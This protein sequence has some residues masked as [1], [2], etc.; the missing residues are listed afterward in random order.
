M[1]DRIMMV[2]TGGAYYKETAPPSEIAMIALLTK[3][4][5]AISKLCE[6]YSVRKLE[7]F[8]SANTDSWNAETSDVDFV[9]DLGDFGPGVAD[10]YLDLIDELQQLLGRPVTMITYDS[11]RN[12]YF[13][14]EVDETKV[15]FYEASHSQAIA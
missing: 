10:R 3:N 9:V 12:P 2:R 5:V 6:K 4:K 8:G 14:E 13:K 1:S 11:I 15:M 7:V